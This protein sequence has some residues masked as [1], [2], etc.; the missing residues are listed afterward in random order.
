MR[1]LE[2]S[3]IVAASAAILAVAAVMLPAAASAQ[4][5]LL[6]N[7][8]LTQ[9]TGGAPD[10]WQPQ[11]WL[12]G[13]SSNYNS[14]LT[15]LPQENPAE[16]EVQNPAPDDARWVQDIHLDP[17]WYHFTA[18]VRTD[19]VGSAATGANLSILQD[20]I[21]SHDVRGTSIWQPIGFYLQFV[22][23]GGADV[24]LA[25]RLGFYSSPNTGT[26]YFRN[27]AATIVD[28][29]ATGGDPTFQY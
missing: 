28:G 18:E 22:R 6:L 9:G 16:L 8:D 21:G 13:Q 3:L 14:P 27:I 4:S 17:G 7:P 29:P 24:T 19:N 25:A 11:S 23:P 5:N 26:A 1:Q 2:R 20:W 15:W 12:A 10:N